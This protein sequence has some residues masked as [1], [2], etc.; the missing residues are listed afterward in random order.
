VR[1][2]VEALPS[3]VVVVVVAMLVA[4]AYESSSSSLLKTRTLNG[5]PGTGSLDQLTS[6]RYSPG[7]V[8]L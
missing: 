2:A 6:T 4:A 5:E 1:L 8:T 3:L 7:S